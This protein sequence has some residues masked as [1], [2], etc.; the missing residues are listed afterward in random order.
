VEPRRNIELKARDADRPRSAAVCKSIGAEGRGVLI[1]R[2]TYFNASRGR[3]K[4]REERGRTAQLIAYERPDLSEERASRYRLIEI[5]EPDELK[6]ALATTLG[7]KVV[8]A[9]ERRL[10]LWE[11]NVRIHLD[12]VE[13]LGGFLEFEAVASVDS[14]LAREADQVG[15]LRT[16]FAIDAGDLIGGS[17]C[18]LVMGDTRGPISAG[19]SSIELA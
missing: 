14:D 16:A 1:Q 8:V 10:F 17:Y 4:L 9:K 2:D 7:V 13:G 11:G 19:R 5:A 3:L 12:V 18:D 15:R 6:A